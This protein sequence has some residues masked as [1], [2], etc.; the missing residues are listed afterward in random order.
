MS[1]ILSPN[2]LRE[3]T[4]YAQ[5]AAQRRVLDE[6]GIPYKTVGSRTIVLEAHITAWIEGRPVRRTVEPDLS[7]VI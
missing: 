5:A 2:D 3:I 7:S 4:G 6:Q 1:A